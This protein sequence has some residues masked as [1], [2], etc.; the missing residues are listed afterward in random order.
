MKQGL[1]TL[2][3]VIGWVVFISL[4]WVCN[5]FALKT[6]FGFIAISFALVTGWRIGGSTYEG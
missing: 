2:G 5:S 3:C 6:V 1:I 4:I